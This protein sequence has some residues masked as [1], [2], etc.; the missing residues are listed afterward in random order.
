M[1]STTHVAS[2]QLGMVHTVQMLPRVVD[3]RQR[4]HQTLGIHAAKTQR[5]RS[6]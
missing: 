4:L 1:F 5:R 2:L 6:S 3:Y